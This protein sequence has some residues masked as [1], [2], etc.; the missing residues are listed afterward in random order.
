MLGFPP[1]PFFYL[2]RILIL[3]SQIEVGVQRVADEIERRFKG[4]KVRWDSDS[5]INAVRPIDSHLLI[6]WLFSHYAQIIICGILKG[7]FVFLTDLCRCLKRPY[8]CYFVEASSYSGQTQSGH[9]ELLSR[10]VPSKF[11]GRKIVRQPSCG[12]HTY[13]HTPQPAHR[14][15]III[16]KTA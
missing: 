11:K 8:S 3:L 4:E 1:Y 5:D 6:K 13:T 16:R 12:R 9:V 2:Q 15:R 10:V 14:A 7:A